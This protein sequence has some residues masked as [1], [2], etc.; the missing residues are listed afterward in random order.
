MRVIEDYQRREKTYEQAITAYQ[1]RVSDLMKD[2]RLGDLEKRVSVLSS[3][4]TELR[5]NFV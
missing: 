4:N 3:Q 5:N 1:K 2:T